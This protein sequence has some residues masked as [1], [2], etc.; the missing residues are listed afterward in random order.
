[1]TLDQPHELTQGSLVYDSDL[2][3]DVPW[4]FTTL[5][6]DST[7]GNPVPL[8]EEVR[9]MLTDGSLAVVTGH[10]NREVSFRLQVAAADGQ[11]MAQA[12]AAL[13]AEK[14]AERPSPLVWTPPMVGAWPAVFDVVHMD[15]QRDHSAGWDIDERFRQHRFYTITL[16][17]LPWARDPEATV[18]E[19]LPR[20]TDPNLPATYQVID[21][22]TSLTGWEVTDNYGGW[23]GEA[24]S[25]PG[26]G[27]IQASGTATASTSPRYL[28][29]N[30][31]GSVTMGTTPYLTVDV[32]QSHTLQPLDSPIAIAVTSGG[33]G[34]GNLPILAMQAIE[35]AG[36]GP[37][38]RY[39]V[40][41]PAT[42]TKLFVSAGWV[43][44][45]GGSTALYWRIYEVGRTD[46]IEVNGSS[47]F[48]IART[49]EVGGTAPTQAA[50]SF[51]AGPDPLIGSSALVY[52]GSSEVV[53]MRTLRTSSAT[54]TVDT[55]MISGARNDLSA[56]MV[57]RVP[58]SR[59]SQ[60]T[61]TLL[62]RLSFTGSKT[63]AWQARVMSSTGTSIPGSDLVVSGSSLITNS[64]TDPW[65]I[66]SLA[67]IQMPVIAVEGS[68][69]HVVEVTLSMTS[70]GNTV[71][72]DEG[73]LCDTDAGAVTVLHEPS[74]YQLSSVEL[75]SPQL[76]APRSA[77]IGTWLTYGTQ[78]ISRLVDAF[79]AHLFKPG[80]LHVFTA[81]D[82]AK[83][84]T[85]ELTYYRRYH[86]HPGPDLPEDAA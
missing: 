15:I 35:I 43:A 50:L 30:R 10:G 8:V 69:T 83:Y 2:D 1:M 65:R 12:E 79:G 76:D 42:F 75:R 9:S 71:T 56:P 57:F 29:L 77:V 16:V 78:D 22:C 38:T 62:A 45:P 58:V 17:C 74:S 64:T 23:T 37:A 49:A 3:P 85:C 60:A 39:I 59:L 31:T 41:P 80:L 36:V 86:T 44:R 67:A 82:L 66:H 26:D 40:E 7:F 84:A 14:M 28:N 72:V 68:T 20:P 25:L 27:S 47:G 48:Q 21:A 51:D 53:P 54:V 18:I 55:T 61:Y 19:A 5:A 81:T 63:V 32:V 6:E 11:A 24:I 4:A 52:T 70:G 46:R 13:M 73:W 34:T 33:Q